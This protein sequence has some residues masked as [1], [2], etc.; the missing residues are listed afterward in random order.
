MARAL[1]RRCRAG[2]GAAPVGGR[3]SDDDDDDDEPLLTSPP[4]LI[5]V[6]SAVSASAVAAVPGRLPGSKSPPLPPSSSAA[7]AVAESGSGRGLSP[8]AG[9]I[10]N[11]GRVLLGCPLVALRAAAKAAR[12]PPCGPQEPRF[13]VKAGLRSSNEVCGG[14]GGC[15]TV[16]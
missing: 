7:I 2:R 6:T 1:F 14:G 5:R 4:I 15:C 9:S 3:P 8:A 10:S 13:N 11:D 16:M 12:R